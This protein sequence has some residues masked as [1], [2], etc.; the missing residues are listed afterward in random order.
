MRYIFLAS[1]L[2]MALLNVPHIISMQSNAQS[3]TKQN[4][5]PNVLSI[6]AYDIVNNALIENKNG[7]RFFNIQGFNNYLDTHTDIPHKDLLDAQH[8]IVKSLLNQKILHQDRRLQEI[9][10]FYRELVREYL[11]RNKEKP[12]SVLPATIEQ[13]KKLTTECFQDCFAYNINGYDQAMHIAK[14]RWEMCDCGHKD[15]NWPLT[16]INK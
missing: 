7:T 8:V 3:S 13:Y 9:A 5:T 15:F 2:I 6:Q 12:E 1:T 11:K 10:F 14:H 4:N 16:R